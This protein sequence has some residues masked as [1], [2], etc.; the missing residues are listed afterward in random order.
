M[1][2]G[3]LVYVGYIVLIVK[4]IE[5]GVLLGVVVL[6]VDLLLLLVVLLVL[7]LLG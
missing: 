4:V 2:I 7:V 3:V 6:M 1:L 5:F